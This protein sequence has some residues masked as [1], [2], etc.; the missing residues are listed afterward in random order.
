MDTAHLHQLLEALTV[1][2][3]TDL[4]LKPGSAPRVRRKGVL[5]CVAGEQSLTRADVADLALALFGG[6]GHAAQIDGGIAATHAVDG[7]G[8]FRVRAYR[9]RGSIA[10]VVKRIP[11]TVDTLVELGLPDQ[12]RALSELEH[13]LV[14]VAGPPHSGRRRT[15]ASMLDHVNRV[16]AA[17]IVAIERPVE[18]LH[19]DAMGSVSQLEVGTDALSFADGLRNALDADADVIVASDIDDADAAA[20]TLTAAED[21]LLVMV[22]IEA[23]SGVDALQQFVDLFPTERRDGVRLSLAGLL[24]GVITQRL[25]PRASGTGRVP[26]VEVVMA[27]NAVCEC[28]FD[29]T[30]MPGIADLVDYGRSEGMQSFVSATAELMSGGAIDLRGALAVNDDWTR[31]H[32]E[33]D[34][35]G[36]LAS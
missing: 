6:H 5:E 26:V 25:A 34:R 16:R 8:R 35:W 36:V 9:Q 32:T 3:A 19:R 14:L 2:G 29:V 33:L 27:T 30:T 28:L 4:H 18:L 1:P 7:V 22:G 12:V 17:H 21:G 24:R 15:L 31:L 11:D 10:L 13:G 20:A 23:S